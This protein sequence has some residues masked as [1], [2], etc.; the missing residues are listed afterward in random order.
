MQHINLMCTFFTV[1]ALYTT[2]LNKSNFK[3]YLKK[4]ILKENLECNQYELQSIV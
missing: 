3:I 2:T 1:I 4:Y